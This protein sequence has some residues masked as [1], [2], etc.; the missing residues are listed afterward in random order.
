MMSTPDMTLDPLYIIMD[1]LH[2][3]GIETQGVNSSEVGNLWSC[4]KERA[5]E[6]ENR[7]DAESHR[8]SIYTSISRT[9]YIKRGSRPGEDYI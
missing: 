8:G 3:V 9:D 5:A 2:L 1:R 7:R 6:I 4:F